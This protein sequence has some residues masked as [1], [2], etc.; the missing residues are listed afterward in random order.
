MG[1][2]QQ[3]Y[4]IYQE[5]LKDYPTYPDKKDL[6]ERLARV[7]TTLKKKDEATEFERLAREQA[8]L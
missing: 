4:S 5:V 8:A 7:A 3:A 1:R 6:Y 2:A